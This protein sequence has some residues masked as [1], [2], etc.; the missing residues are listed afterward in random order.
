MT[1]ISNSFIPNV[2][3]TGVGLE[4]A[5]ISNTSKALIAPTAKCFSLQLENQSLRNVGS[6]STTA[7][8]SQTPLT[9]TDE[10][11]VLLQRL[12]NENPDL[13]KEL[14]IIEDETSSP[15]PNPPSPYKVQRSNLPPNIEDEIS[16]PLPNPP[17]PYEV[18]RSDLSSD[19]EDQT[20]S[21]LPNLP[22]PYEVQRSDLSSDIEDQTSSPLPN[23]P[24]PYEVQRSDLSSDEEEAPRKLLKR[25]TIAPIQEASTS[26]T[27]SNEL[28]RRRAWTSKELDIVARLHKKWG[29]RWAL[30]AREV[31][32]RTPKAIQCFVGEHPEI[33][34]NYD[35]LDPNADTLSQHVKRAWTLEENE[36][37]LHLYR[38]HGK[39]V[40]VASKVYKKEAPNRALR[41]ISIH[42]STLIERIKK[43]GT[44]L[45]QKNFENERRIAMWTPEEERI[46]I[47]RAEAY[48]RSE[49]KIDLEFFKQ[50]QSVMPDRSIGSLKGKF[51][52]LVTQ[53]RVN[54]VH[55]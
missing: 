51:Y 4:V 46:L 14:G 27:K 26:L 49:Q 10:T 30:I 8:F 36:R 12:I 41:S 18:Q 42:L 35:R 6:T 20:S 28:F 44:D 39:V 24:S 16:S 32:G 55:F 5:G 2:S 9:E 40:A 31:K 1:S 19:I 15:L 7:P 45:A 54:N 37:L 22:S 38:S 13:F 34:K 53:Q 47:E 50:V 43:R 33:F 52:K 23:L 29:N 48:A 11:M 3:Q 17:S 25:K 21:P